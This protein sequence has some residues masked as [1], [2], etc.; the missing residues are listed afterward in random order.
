MKNDDLRADRDELDHFVPRTPAK[1]GNNL[2]MQVAAGVFLG[3]LA[4]WLVQLA[5][6]MLYAKLMLATVTFGG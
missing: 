2:V 4:L 6:T 5:A 1:R 3:G